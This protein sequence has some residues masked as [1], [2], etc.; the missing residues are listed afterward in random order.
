MLIGLSDFVVIGGY[1]EISNFHLVFWGFRFGDYFPMS[2]VLH[3]KW[4]GWILGW[5]TASDDVDDDDVVAV[6]LLM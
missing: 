1:W 5:P 6:M 2:P 4:N 3:R